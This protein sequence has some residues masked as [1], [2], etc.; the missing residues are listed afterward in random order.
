MSKQ[1][2][3]LALTG[4]ALLDSAR[5]NKGTAFTEK[6]RAAFGLRGRLPFAVNT[7]EQQVER[8]YAQYKDH[9]VAIRQNAFLQSLKAQNWTLFYA[10]ITRHLEEMF[11]VI[12]TPTEADAIANY[13]HLFRRSEGLFLSPPSVDNM[14]KDFLDACD[15]RVLDLIVVSDAEAILGIGDQ[16]S[17]GIGISSAKAVIYTLAAGVDPAKALAVTL[18]VGTNNEKLLKDD[19]YIGYRERR[20]HGRPYDDFVDKFVGLV[21]KHQSKALLHFED[22]GVSNAQRLLQRHRDTHPIFNDDIQGTGAVTLA[23]LQAAISVT[24][25][26]LQDQRIVVFGAGSAGLGIARQLRDAMRVATGLSKEDAAKRFWLIDKYGLIKES[27]G[28]KIRDDL[29]SEFIRREDDW[30]TD[31]NQLAEVV[32]RVKPTVLI[33]TSTQPGSFTEGIIKE[34]AKHVERPII[35]PLSNPTR[36]HEV[37]PKDANAWTN[38]KALIATGSPFHPVDIP[39]K[40]KKYV[41]AECNN[42]L[43][44]PG[45]G[46]GTILSRSKKMTDKMI[47]AGAQKL[48]ELAPALKDPDDALLTPFGDAAKVNFEVALAVIDQAVEEGVADA[49]VP[50]TDRRKWAEAQLWKPEYVEYEYS[51]QGL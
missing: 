20:L 9:D 34:M 32:K 45:L 25:S 15:G 23:A 19:L 27:L 3:K 50:K 44:Y 17:G 40:S 35:F 6:E 47:I 38:G 8:A 41:I 4:E 48:A 12:Y 10:L 13:S 37:Q 11:P 28:D 18:D 39:G 24:S 2:L 46:L 29:D 5:Y 30:G 14:E 49:D 21:R 7:L 51:A 1:P 31:E 33:G 22:F 26:K 36:L 16:G 43:I 42:A